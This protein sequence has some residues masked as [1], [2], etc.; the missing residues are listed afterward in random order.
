MIC[1]KKEKPDKLQAHAIAMICTNVHQGHQVHLA[2]QVSMENQA[3]VVNQVEKANLVFKVRKDM[4]SLVD[5]AGFAHRVPKV[6]A[7]HPALLDQWDQRDYRALMEAWVRVPSLARLDH[8]VHLVNQA[9]Q[10]KMAQRDLMDSQESLELKE[11]L[12]RRE[13]QDQQAKLADKDHQVQ[14]ANLVELVHKDHQGQPA[15]LELGLLE[16]VNLDNLEK[17]AC[18]VKMLSIVHVQGETKLLQL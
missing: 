7:G 5:H 14:M 2:K 18:P 1:L 6:Q 10:V 3:S 17:L 12:D 16:M 13:H 15:M 4:L 8:Q 11:K 9:E